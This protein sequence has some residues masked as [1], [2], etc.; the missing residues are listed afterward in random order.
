M[1]V[2]N[3][4]S[5]YKRS[6]SVNIQDIAQYRQLCGYL[7]MYYY[8][9]RSQLDFPDITNIIVNNIPT[10]CFVPVF[11][12]SYTNCRVG[13]LSQITLQGIKEHEPFTIKSSKS[14][15]E[16]IVPAL[17]IYEPEILNGI[18]DDTLLMPISYDHLKNAINRV[19]NQLHIETPSGTL[20]A[21]HIFRH[22]FAT[23]ENNRGTEIKL[24]SHALGHLNNDTTQKYIH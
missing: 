9:Y 14:K 3:P 5:I 21:T 23:F 6:L 10:L 4:V 1:E 17:N 11:F 16:R 7:R 20:N 15:H 24:I 13:E 12:L 19:K 18:P 8:F 2:K 22:L